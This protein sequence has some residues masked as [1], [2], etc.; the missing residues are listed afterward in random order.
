VLLPEL[1][2]FQLP[3]VQIVWGGDGT[4]IPLPSLSTHVN[5]KIYQTVVL[6]TVLYGRETWFLISK[7]FKNM[8]LRRLFGHKMEEMTITN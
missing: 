7:I 3:L 6:S 1:I 8:V 5:I 2:V 4:S